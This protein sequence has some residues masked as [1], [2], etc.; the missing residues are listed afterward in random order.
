[1]RITLFSRFMVF[2]PYW[3]QDYPRPPKESVSYLKLRASVDY[4]EEVHGLVKN[5][6]PIQGYLRQR[7]V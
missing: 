5:F 2:L 3:V 6:S 7:L 1:M 4:G